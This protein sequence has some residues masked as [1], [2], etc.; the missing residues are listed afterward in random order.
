[1]TS[2]S[3]RACSRGAAAAACW[4]AGLGT[5]VPAAMAAEPAPLLYFF[6]AEELEYRVTDGDDSVNW[7]AQGWVGGDVNRAW[8]KTE[9]EALVDSGVEAA[10]IQALY[11][12]QISD[13]FDAQVGVRYDFEPDPERAF[14][15]FGVQSL[16]PYFFEIDAAGFVSE[17]GDLSA[18]FEAEYELL[19]TQQLVLQPS[20]EVNFAAQEVEELGIG[21]GVN[22]V[23]LGLRL[24][25]EIE[26][27]FAPYIGVN[28]E[29]NLGETA[30]FARDE[31]E[32]VDNLSFVTGIRFWF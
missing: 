31:G 17:D 26:R 22:D 1:M 18:R 5:L 21:S 29:R 27:E 20:L 24:R 13:F 32:D 16:S 8:F 2:R 7:E 9:G 6:Q 28:W 19:I 15:V 10:E 12:R 14:A 23:E 4:A 11:S 25:Y 3:A 30:D